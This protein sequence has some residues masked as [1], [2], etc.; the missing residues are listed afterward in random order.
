MRPRRIRNRGEITVLVTNKGNSTEVYTLAP[1]DREQALHFDPSDL[2]LQIAPCE[3][4]KAVFFVRPTRRPFIGFGSKLYAFEVGAVPGSGGSIQ[5]LPGEVMTTP[6]IPWWLLVFLL[7]L[8][9]L[10]CF[11]LYLF[12]KPQPPVTTT[13][14][15]TVTV[16]HQTLEGWLTSTANGFNGR[17]TGTYDIRYKTATQ[18]A[19]L[20]VTGTAHFNNTATAN[21]QKTVDAQGTAARS[22]EIQNAIAATGVIQTK[23]MAAQQT[24]QAEPT[25]APK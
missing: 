4:G 13:P 12:I 19:N 25:P 16:Y 5:A 2:P 21:A 3:T 15:N 20:T 18:A 23:T 1:R 24:A 17:Q 8:L 10:L 9:L 7:L 6:S 11:L 22:V 14:N